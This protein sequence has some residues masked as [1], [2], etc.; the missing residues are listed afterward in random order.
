MKIKWV[1]KATQ[2]HIG[3]TSK[4]RGVYS[5]R[6]FKETDKNKVMTK[7]MN[8]GQFKRCMFGDDL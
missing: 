7:Q 8:S 3:Y 1:V 5:K 2:R 4:N 6:L